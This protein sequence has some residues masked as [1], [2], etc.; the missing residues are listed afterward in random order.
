MYH[1]KDR[2]HWHKV[3]TTRARN[4]PTSTLFRLVHFTAMIPSGINPTNTCASEQRQS[5]FEPE[6]KRNQISRRTS[7]RSSSHRSVRFLP[8]LRFLAASA[9][10]RST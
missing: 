8:N 9:R 4:V 3:D 5:L 7:T 10:V 2:Y 6:V 1:V